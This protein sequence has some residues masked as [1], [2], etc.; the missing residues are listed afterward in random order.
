MP[1]GLFHARDSA[2]ALTLGQYG[3]Q[4]TNDLTRQDGAAEGHR[5][6]RCA[7]AARADR[8][9][10][11]AGG[12]LPCARPNRFLG[13]LACVQWART[14]RVINQPSRPSWR[15]ASSSSSKTAKPPPPCAQPRRPRG[16]RAWSW[17]D[18][19][20]RRWSLRRQGAGILAGLDAAGTDHQPPS[21]PLWRARR[22]RTLGADW[23]RFVIHRLGGARPV[24]WATNLSGKLPPE[25]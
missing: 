17:R 3:L 16:H 4:F 6:C 5:S 12:C 1:L 11:A 25:A 22:N 13:P 7:T 21:T 18:C 14:T 10:S 15:L 20:G 8:A 2:P 23:Q 24:V 9:R 19:C